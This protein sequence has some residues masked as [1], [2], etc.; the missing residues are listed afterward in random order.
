MN[1]TE[2]SEVTTDKAYSEV[3]V[4][5]DAGIIRGVSLLSPV[6]KNGRKYSE[7]S[8]NDAKSL[9]EN[10][11]YY[12]DHPTISETKDRM[13]V[14]SVRDLAGMISNVR[15]EGTYPEI[16]VR[17]DIQLLKGTPITES[18]LSIAE[19]MPMMAGNSHRVMASV[20]RG[21]DGIDMVDRIER[22]MGME[23]VTDPATTQG[24]FESVVNPDDLKTEDEPMT[25]AELKE[26]HPEIFAAAIAEQTAKITEQDT[27]IVEQDTKIVTLET[28]IAEIDEAE[29]KTARAKV[30]DEKIAAANL[31]AHA[32]TDTFKETLE[33]ASDD[34]Q[35]DKLIEDRKA[36]AGTTKKVKTPEND[37]DK[38]LGE[39]AAPVDGD[40]V[41]EVSRKMFG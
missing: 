18:I 7:A 2:I 13:G 41:Q 29:E 40:V 1:P 20:K 23:L 16:K 24:L 31:P 30:I 38:Y 10:T 32:V 17:G 8:I 12:V 9:Y 37:V 4:D 14:R 22:V 27:K 36:I 21:A 26:K 15:S 19:Q 6:S 34:A 35:I 11:R 28:R 5:R 33:S 3:I 25:L 39:Q